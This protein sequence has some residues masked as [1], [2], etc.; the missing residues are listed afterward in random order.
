MKKYKHKKL[1]ILLDV[2]VTAF[3]PLILMFRE[4]SDIYADTELSERFS[5]IACFSFFWGREKNKQ[6]KQK[7]TTII[8]IIVV[9]NNN[10]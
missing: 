4:I 9:N 1:L 2:F 10:S 3:L 7:T 8:I 5:D 6:N